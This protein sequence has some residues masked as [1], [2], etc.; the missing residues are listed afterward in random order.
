MFTYRTL[1]SMA[2]AVLTKNSPFYIQFFVSKWCHLNCRMCNIVEANAGV[3]PFPSSQIEPLVKNLVAIGAGVVL[4]TG[5]EPFFR[6]DIVE[7][8]KQ[9]KKATV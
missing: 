8:V 5:G 6:D 1:K 7:I 9:L 4:L 2:K 3:T